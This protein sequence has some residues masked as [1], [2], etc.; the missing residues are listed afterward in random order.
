MSEFVPLTT[1][2][3]PWFN[4]PLAE[5]PSC[6]SL[7]LPVGSQPRGGLKI[8][9]RGWSWDALSPALRRRMAAQFDIARDP[10]NKDEGD[11][12]WDLEARRADFQSRWAALKTG[13][14]NDMAKYDEQLDKLNGELDALKDD[15]GEVKS[16]S[17]TERRAAIER[18]RRRWKECDN[19]RQGVIRSEPP[20]P[21][22]G[23][24][25]ASPEPA[26]TSPQQGGPVPE[27]VSWM[28]NH[29]RMAKDA[30]RLA[31]RDDAIKACMQE[32]NCTYRIARAAWGEVPSEMKRAARQTD[33]A[34]TGHSARSATGT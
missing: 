6:L 33:R 27:A 8:L 11:F 19:R 22:E 5:V 20:W 1:A 12:W 30:D 21:P 17:P 34:A 13:P 18:V 23:D 24:A 29:T 2:L 16:A 15:E 26:T 4:K 9:L 32:A 3:E 14:R 28:L 25:V 7:L 10:A 31:K